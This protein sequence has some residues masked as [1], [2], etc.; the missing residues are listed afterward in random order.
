MEARVGIEPTNAAF[1]EPCLTTWLPRPPFFYPSDLSAL[2]QAK[3]SPNSISL[4]LGAAHNRSAEIGVLPDWRIIA[5]QQ[6]L[7]A[8]TKRAPFLVGTRLRQVAALGFHALD[9]LSAAQS[10]ELYENVV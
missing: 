8:T 7:S 1:A 6:S 5:I 10:R 9:R 4:L 3:Q 2:A